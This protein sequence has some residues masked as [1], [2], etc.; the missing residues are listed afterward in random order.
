[1]RYPLKLKRVSPKL[2]MNVSGSCVLDCS[3]SRLIPN[4]DLPLVVVRVSER[5]FLPKPCDANQ[6]STSRLSGLSAGT[7]TE[8]V[9]LSVREVIMAL[10][11]TETNVMR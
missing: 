10:T 4:M 7:T 6:V 11:M 3:G 9:T 1:M 2:G 8:A 5:A